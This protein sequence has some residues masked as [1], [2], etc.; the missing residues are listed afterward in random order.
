MLWR[1]MSKAKSC[2]MSSLASPFRDRV[3][4][5]GARVD[6]LADG[7][8]AAEAIPNQAGGSR[9]VDVSRSFVGASMIGRA[10]DHRD[11]GVARGRSA[12]IRA[13]SLAIEHGGGRA[14]GARPP[15]AY[16]EEAFSDGQAMDRTCRRSP[17]R[18]Q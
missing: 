7:V 10:D 16:G 4:D 9:D 2:T 6:V 11:V 15:G 3:V 17:W 1:L 13:K 18:F 8:T 5:D 14:L 12:R